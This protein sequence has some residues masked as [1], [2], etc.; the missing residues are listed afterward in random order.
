[1]FRRLM[2]DETGFIVSAELVLV[3]TLAFCGV[4]VGMS[5]VRD[6]LVQELGD[7]AEAIGALNQSYAWRQITANDS[8]NGEL[9]ASCQGSGFF[10]QTDDCDCDAIEFG[11]ITP[12]SDPNNAD[13]GTAG[14]GEGG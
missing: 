10:D 6:A 13:T 1:M 11:T 8:A 3:F 7:V 5:V 12:K 14:S 9:H 2:N 4:A